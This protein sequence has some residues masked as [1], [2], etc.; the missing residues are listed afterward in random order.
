MITWIQNLFHT[1]SGFFDAIGALILKLVDDLK[2][3]GEY[4]SQSVQ[5]VYAA[6]QLIPEYYVA[7]GILII[8]V[9]VIYIVAGRQAGGD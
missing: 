2:L 4:I 9:L 3:L 6:F 1:I 5:F 8:T 7:F